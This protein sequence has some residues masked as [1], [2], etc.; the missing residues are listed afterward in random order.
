M[1]KD[2]EKRKVKQKMRFSLDMYTAKIANPEFHVFRHKARGN[3]IVSYEC[4]GYRKQQK[5]CTYHRI[6][7][8]ALKQCVLQ[9]IK[10][11]WYEAKSDIRSFKAK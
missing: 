5:K 7:E 3:M 11:M 1:L 2:A 10:L 9:K 4:S 8:D 6:D